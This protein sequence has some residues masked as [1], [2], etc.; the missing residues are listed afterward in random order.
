MRH[1]LSCV[2]SVPPTIAEIVELLNSRG[3]PEQLT[4]WAKTP[5]GE[6]L[7]GTTFVVT[8]RYDD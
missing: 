2:C 4:E 5:V 7:A 1:G 6:A 3:R 8:E